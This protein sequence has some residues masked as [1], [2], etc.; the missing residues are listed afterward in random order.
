[1]KGSPSARARL[2]LMRKGEG[3]PEPLI[4]DPFREPLA[5]IQLKVEEAIHTQASRAGGL[6]EVAWGNLLAV[7][8]APRHLLR[9]QLV[10]LGYAGAG[11][12][13]DDEAVIQ[14]AAGVELLHL[15]MLV[16]DDL[17]DGGTQRRGLPTLHVAL[18]RAAPHLPASI[19]RSLT[20]VVGDLVHSRAVDIMTSAAWGKAG[21]AQACHFIF[22]GA[23]RAGLGQFSDLLG[24]SNL[25]DPPDAG[26]VFRGALL[27][28]GAWHSVPAPLAAGMRL[29]SSSISVDQALAWG[30]HVGLAL[31]GADDLA[32]L[33]T[34]SSVSGKD[35]LQDL[36]EGRLS[37]PL[38]LL[39][40]NLTQS[41]R[42]LMDEFPHMGVLTPTARRDLMDLLT[43]HRLVHIGVEFL[44]HELDQA[45]TLSSQWGGIL[46]E[47]MSRVEQGLRRHIH[48][49]EKG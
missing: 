13:S 10:L 42:T 37:L 18:T 43:R 27:N 8:R 23:E 14:F 17:M 45:T 11:G 46:G 34:P 7:S 33:V 19:I 26:E 30:S 2:R 6:W 15:F 22:E 40:R 32:D 31:Q 49:L 3:M 47:G 9:P 29:F 12:S 20:V 44:L 38:H 48:S 4:H 16:H 21:G 24:F 1:M 35:G 36:R 41:E 5:R 39:R 28:K 25:G